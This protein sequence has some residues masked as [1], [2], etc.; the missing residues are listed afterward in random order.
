[1][2]AYVYTRIGVKKAENNMLKIFKQFDTDGNGELS[3][4]EL[5]LGITKSLKIDDFCEDDLAMMMDRFDKN[6]DG[7]ITYEE[8]L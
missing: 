6:G 5:R 2:E 4:D 1:M 7:S 8:F 3:M